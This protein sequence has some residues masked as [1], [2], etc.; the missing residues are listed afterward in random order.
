[1][2]KYIFEDDDLKKNISDLEKSWENLK[3]S[4]SY[5]FSYTANDAVNDGA[6][7]DITDIS[8]NTFAKDGYTVR[9]TSNIINTLSYMNPELLALVN[10]DHI[11]DYFYKDDIKNELYEEGFKSL[12]IPLCIKTERKWD[13]CEDKTYYYNVWACLDGTSGNAVHFMFPE[14]Y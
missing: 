8:E 9:M 1:M 6:L 11:L 13:K 5:V 12:P 7:V 4:N 2:D 14:D 10:I 3:M